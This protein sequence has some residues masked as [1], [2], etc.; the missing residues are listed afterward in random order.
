MGAYWS[1][2]LLKTT[3]AR[4]RLSLLI[5]MF[6]VN[7][8]GRTN[9]RARATIGAPDVTVKS[10]LMPAGRKVTMGPFCM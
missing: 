3:G 10:S 9:G 5:S 8:S 1:I 4:T 7:E 6:I 2:E